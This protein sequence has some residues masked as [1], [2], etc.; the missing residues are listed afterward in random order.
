MP[1][2]KYV[3]PKEITACELKDQYYTSR[4]L[5]DILGISMNTLADYRRRGTGPKFIA[6]GYHTY[7]YAK[8]DIFA[9]LE[10]RKR[11]STSATRNYDLQS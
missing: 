5:A 11:A 6:F 1:R 2:I 7:R 8:A 3:T 4:E 10:E 9:Y